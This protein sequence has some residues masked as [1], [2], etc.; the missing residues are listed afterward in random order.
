MHVAEAQILN[1]HT[2]S[3]TTSLKSLQMFLCDS[4][5]KYPHNAQLLYLLVKL[6]SASSAISPTRRY[7]EIQYI[8]Q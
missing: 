7:F 5:R 3:T 6:R 2:W 8:Y 1:F 4:I